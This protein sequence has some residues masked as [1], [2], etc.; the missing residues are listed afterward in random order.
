MCSIAMSKESDVCA[1]GAAENPAPAGEISGSETVASP[2]TR[3]MICKGRAPFTRSR[4]VEGTVI[5]RL[6]G[7]GTHIVEEVSRLN[8]VPE[9]EWHLFLKRFSWRHRG[10]IATIHGFEQG[11]P[12]T[13]IPSARLASAALEDV[14][15]CSLVRLTVGGGV[16]LVAPRPCTIRVQLTGE[17]AERA[18]E[19]ETVDG[20]FVRLAFRATELPQHLD[21][22]AP[23]E[24]NAPPH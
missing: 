24:L 9:L 8:V 13:R 3:T 18:L 20:A 11:R 7:M 23:E 5:A 4:L 10:W 12:V 17:D 22:V 19:V 1:E 15:S 21:G 16:S 14:D 6:F 2:S